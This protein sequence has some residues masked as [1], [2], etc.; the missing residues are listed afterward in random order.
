M[1]TTYRTHSVERTERPWGWYESID[2]ASFGHSGLKVKRIGV[3][4]GKQISLQKHAQRA[5]HWVVVRGTAIVTLGQQDGSLK[6][7]TLQVG[8]HCDI[9]LGQIHRLANR[10]NDP[11][12]IVE[13]QLG[14]YLG[15][16][17]ITR[18]QDDF[19]RA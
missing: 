8:Q 17:D 15:E 5:E 4:P 2:E 10:T 19:G 12:E 14:S 18:L 16:D 1:T 7:I 13:V 6:E 9:A 11:V 3:H